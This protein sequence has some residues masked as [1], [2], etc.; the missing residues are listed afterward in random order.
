MKAKILEKWICKLC[1]P[2]TCFKILAFSVVLNAIYDHLRSDSAF[3]S[4]GVDPSNTSLLLQRM[5]WFVFFFL[6]YF[7]ILP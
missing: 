1:I 3:V 7:Q 2:N 6:S 4:C 5:V